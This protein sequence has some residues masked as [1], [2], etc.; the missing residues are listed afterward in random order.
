MLRSLNFY[1]QYSRYWS[2]EQYMKII[3][4]YLKKKW[5][6]QSGWTAWIFFFIW[7]S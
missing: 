6:M 1:V 4:D 3:Y 5:K 7:S 2:S